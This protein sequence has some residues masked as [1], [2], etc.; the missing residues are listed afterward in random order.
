MAIVHEEAKVRSTGLLRRLCH[1]DKYH[2]IIADM[3]PVMAEEI[4]TYHNQRN[5]K[6]IPARIDAYAEDQKLNRWYRG[7]SGIGFDRDGQLVNGQNRLWACVKSGVTIKDCLIVFNCDSDSRGV[8]DRHKCRTVADG[9]TLTGTA[10]DGDIVSTAIVF[11]DAPSPLQS[12]RYAG[13]DVV[14][15]YID[16]FRDDIEWSCRITTGCQ[17]VKHAV[18]RAVLARASAAKNGDAQVRQR[19]E[20]FVEIVSTGACQ[21]VE[22]SAATLF[23]EF[24]IRNKSLRAGGASNRTE[25]YRYVQNA[26]QAFLE[27]RSLRSLRQNSNDLFPLP[28]EV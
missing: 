12:S 3:T 10:A 5:R 13:V 11:K 25:Y 20:A 19:L 16:N 14:R 28:F 15:P 6:R 17:L 4:V 22:D 23:R 26:V 21:S 7:T 9:L 1:S 2:A 8:E 18:V 24:S 27:H